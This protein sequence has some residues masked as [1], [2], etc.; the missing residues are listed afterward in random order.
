MPLP[1]DVRHDMN[2]IDAVAIYL[3]NNL[4]RHIRIEATLQVHLGIQCSH[5]ENRQEAFLPT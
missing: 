5:A 2:I 4:A 1:S 3:Q